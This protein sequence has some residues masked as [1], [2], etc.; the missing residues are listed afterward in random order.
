MSEVV[1]I[2]DSCAIE[3]KAFRPVQRPCQ[4]QSLVLTEESRCVSRDFQVASEGCESKDVVN[5][6]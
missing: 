4:T 1:G 5:A 6:H 2:V 3:V